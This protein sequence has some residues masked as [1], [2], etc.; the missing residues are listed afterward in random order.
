M[1]THRQ[2]TDEALV[3]RFANGDNQAFDILLNRHKNRVYTYILLIVRNR[4][5]AEDVFQETFMKAIVTIKQGRYVDSGK[6]YAW[7]T[8]IAHNLIIDIFR[9]ERNENTISNDEF[10]DV[11]LF[12]NPKFS[13]ENVEDR[14]VKNQVMKDVSSLVRMLP[15]SQKEVVVLRYYK[16]LSFKDIADQT[17]VSINTA[18]GRMRYAVLNMRRM[19]EGKDLVLSF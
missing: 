11:D 13:D 15:D 3:S 8:R 18:L 14:L 16:N 9:K 19:A 4:D 7:V 1:E 2:M 12:N 5:L 17:G 6:F 10:E